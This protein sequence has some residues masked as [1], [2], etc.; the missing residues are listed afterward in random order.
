M[1]IK[2]SNKFRVSQKD[3][4]YFI[5]WFPLYSKNL[6]LFSL[7]SDHFQITLLLSRVFQIKFISLYILP[8]LFNI[9]FFHSVSQVMKSSM[10]NSK[11]FVI[12][13]L[14]YSFQVYMASHY[15][16]TDPSIFWGKIWFT[17]SGRNCNTWWI[18]LHNDRKSRHRKIK[19][20]RRYERLSCAS[21]QLCLWVGDG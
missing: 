10:I 8:I 19:K 1:N 4:T 20:Q 6:F 16:L 5:S 15:Q 7:Y 2:N 21:C 12:L 18:L 9:F 13:M 11:N 14:S 17:I 3:F